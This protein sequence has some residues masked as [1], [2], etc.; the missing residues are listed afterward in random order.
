MKKNSRVLLLFLAGIYAISSTPFAQ[1]AQGAVDDQEYAPAV[2]S[3]GQVKELKDSVCILAWQ[4]LSLPVW[5][6]MYSS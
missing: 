4:A 6:Q 1:A 5:G 3:A 2:F